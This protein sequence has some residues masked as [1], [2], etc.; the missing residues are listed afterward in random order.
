MSESST[1]NLHTLTLPRFGDQ[2]IIVRV[3]TLFTHNFVVYEELIRNASPFIENALKRVEEEQIEEFELAER[4]VRLPGIRTDTFD[5]YHVWLLTGILHSKEEPDVGDDSTSLLRDELLRLSRLTQLAHHL[6]DV[7]FTDTVCDAILHCLQ[8]LAPRKD[9][10]LLFYGAVFYSIIPNDLP[11]RALIVDTVA[12]TA[13][14]GELAS[15][16]HEQPSRSNQEYIS[17]VLHA[18]VKRFMTPDPT[19]S[20]LAESRTSCKYHNHGAG[21]SCHRKNFPM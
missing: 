1:L 4:I 5:V 3:G 10:N 20:P 11:A 8:D 19:T 6:R 16:K 14:C 2:T 9:T 21:K 18:V 13:Q 15:L 17:D 12:W 7:T